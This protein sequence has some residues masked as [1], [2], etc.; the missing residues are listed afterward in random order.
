MLDIIIEM[1]IKVIKVIGAIL[2][3][4]GEFIAEIIVE[5]YYSHK[6]RV[7]YYVFRVVAFFVCCGIIQWA[8]WYLKQMIASV[9]G[10]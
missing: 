6:D 2:G 3:A 9:F 4:I 7:P 10:G 8:I 1:L 5:W